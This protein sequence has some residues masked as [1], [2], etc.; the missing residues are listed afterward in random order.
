MAFR[1]EQEAFWAGEFG[2]EYVNR[3]QNQTLLTSNIEL[4]SKIMR[5]THGVKNVIELGANIGLNL[6]ALKTLFPSLELSAVEINEL[7]V[8]ELRKNLQ[9]DVHHSSIVEFKPTKKYDLTLIK[10]VLIHI[11]P[12]DLNSVYDLLYQSSNKYIVI[13]EYYNPVPV[14]I[15]Y[16]GHKNKLFKRD[17]CGEMLD[18]FKDLKLVDYGFCYRKDPLYPQ[19]DITWFLLEKNN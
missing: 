14:A 8:N 2:A 6:L 10:G 18:K 13:A 11:N 5:R 7:A 4:F 15:E 9:A 1:N 17:F 16:R 3:N 12:D 19:D